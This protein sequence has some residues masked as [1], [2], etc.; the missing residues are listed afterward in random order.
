MDRDIVAA[1]LAPQIALHK[2]QQQ[3]LEQMHL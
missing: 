1:Q 3:R 2:I